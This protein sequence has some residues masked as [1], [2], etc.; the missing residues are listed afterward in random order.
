[1]H[2]AIVGTGYVGL[3]TGVGLASLGHRVI[4]VDALPDRITAIQAGRTPFLEKGLPEA[5]ERARAAGRL[6]G[7]TDLDR[8]VRDSDLTM[9]AVGTPFKGE[10]IRSFRRSGCSP[11]RGQGVAGRDR[12]PPHCG[13][14]HGC[15]RDDGI[16]R[17]PGRR[18][19]FRP[20]CRRLRP[21]HEPRVSP[22]RLGSR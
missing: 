12:L 4:C 13:Q 19:N 22:R 1:M 6:E 10:R 2:V 18:R 11:R 14:E 5:L 9:I 7:T 15:T 3:T 20:V 16:G 21:V 8:A 17:S